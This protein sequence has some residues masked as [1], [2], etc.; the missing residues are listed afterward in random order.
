[1]KSQFRLALAL[2]ATLLLLIATGILLASDLDTPNDA[3]S[4]VD[5]K[6]PLIDSDTRSVAEVGLW[7]VFR[8]DNGRMGFN[9]DVGVFRPPLAYLDTITLA[10]VT[11][12]AKLLLNVITGPDQIFVMGQ[13]QVWGID[14]ADTSNQWRNDDCL[15]DQ[16]TGDLCFI[17]Y[18]AY[19]DGKIITLQQN[20]FLTNFDLNF[21]LVVLDAATGTEEWR[22]DLGLTGPEIAMDGSDILILTEEGPQGKLLKVDIYHKFHL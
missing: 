10:D 18:M 1:M 9:P 16:I 2:V 7:P 15:P 21:Y 5:P 8:H 4:L 14:K 11:D 17:S 3:A 22:R 12:E 6:K 19:F 20:F 13:F